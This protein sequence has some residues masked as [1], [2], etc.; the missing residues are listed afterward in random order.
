M[1]FT[2]S[3][4]LRRLLMHSATNTKDWGRHRSTLFTLP[5]PVEYDL[6]YPETP[7]LAQ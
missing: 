6:E 1:Q 7:L 5:V 2:S 3:F 4:F